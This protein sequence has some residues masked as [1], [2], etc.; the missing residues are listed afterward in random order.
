MITS[1]RINNSVNASTQKEMPFG[2]GNT[3]FMIAGVIGLATKHDYAYGFPKWVN[4]EHFV[5]PLPKT[6]GISF[7]VFR[8]PA[9]Y[10]GFDI[11]YQEFRVPDNCMIEG[12][13][14]SMKYFEHC[15]TLIRHYFRMKEMC[16]PLKDCILIHY[17]DY[18]KNISF[19]KLDHTYYEKALE[20]FPKK[21]IVVVT[22]NIVAAKKAIG[23]DCEYINNSPIMDFYLLS[24]ADYLILSPSTFS[25]WTAWLSEA[26]VVAPKEYFAGDFADCPFNKDWHLPEWIVI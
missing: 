23:I 11:G 8:V 19:V 17:R 7:K 13:L 9:N 2:L 16:K 12:Y 18:G 3:L 26:K 21:K 22:D 10:K 25:M 15:T 6:D 4:Q 5:N 1:F 24:K 14:G 20:Q